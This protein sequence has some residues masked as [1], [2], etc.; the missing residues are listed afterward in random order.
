M[1]AAIM[2]KSTVSRTWP[3]CLAK[4]TLHH[5]PTY[6]C[7]SLVKNE[8]WRLEEL[9]YEARYECPGWGVKKQNTNQTKPNKNKQ[10]NRKQ[11][12]KG[13][14]SFCEHLPVSLFEVYLIRR[15]G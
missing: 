7:S 13:S 12:K 5:K 11:M 3:S 8:W 6:L 2:S 9:K 1:S 15:L 10:N 14:K 4:C